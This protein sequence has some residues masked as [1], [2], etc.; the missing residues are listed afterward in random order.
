MQKVNW[1]TY[2]KLKY[3]I[4]RKRKFRVDAHDPNFDLPLSNLE[5]EYPDV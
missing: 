1:E 3:G 5:K 4:S 2:C